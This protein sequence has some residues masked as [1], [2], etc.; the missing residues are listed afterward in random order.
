[1]EKKITMCACVVGRLDNR[2]YL[3]VHNRLYVIG[4]FN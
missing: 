4:L 2:Y 3:I 1:M